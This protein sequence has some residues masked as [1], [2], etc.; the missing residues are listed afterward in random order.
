L[1]ASSASVSNQRK[2]VTV[3][4]AGSLWENATTKA[5]TQRARSSA[6]FRQV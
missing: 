6:K 4:M 3:I 5:S 2:G 1:A